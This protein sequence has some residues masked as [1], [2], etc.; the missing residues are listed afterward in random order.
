MFAASMA[1]SDP[2]V[3]LWQ[4]QPNDEGSIGH[5]DFEPCGSAFCG[6]LVYGVNSQGVGGKP[7]NYGRKIV[8]DMS[9]RGNGQYGGGKIWAPDRDK[10]YNAKMELDGDQLTVSGCVLAVCRSQVWTRLR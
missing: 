1:S 4:T 5:I 2:L 9:D 10:T 3:G 8:W 6:T 7:K